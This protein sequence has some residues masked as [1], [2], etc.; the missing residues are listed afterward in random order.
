MGNKIVIVGLLIAL[1][2]ILLPLPVYAQTVVDGDVGHY[3][4]FY[5]AFQRMSFAAND[6]LW[7]FYVDTDTDDLMYRTSDDS[8]A[9]WA[10]EIKIF[11]NAEYGQ[12]VSVEYD[13]TYTYIVASDVTNTYFRRGT[14][15]IDGTFTWSTAWQNTEIGGGSVPD[16]CVDSNG[17]PYVGY[18]WSNYGNVT[19]SSTNDGTWVTDTGN[20]F[21]YQFS[22]TDTSWNVSVVGL[23]NGRVA[24]I[25]SDNNGGENRKIRVSTWTG[26]AWRTERVTVAGTTYHQAVP[27][28]DDLHI[29][30]LNSASDDITYVKYTYNTNSLGAETVLEANGDNYS[31]PVITMTNYNDLYVFWPNGPVA[32]HIYYIKYSNYIGSWGDRVDFVDESIADGIPDSMYYMNCDEE[33]DAATIP[34]YWV[35]DNYSLKVKLVS[36]TASV[37]TLSPSGITAT[38]ATLRGEVTATGTGVITASGFQINTTPSATGSTDVPHSCPCGLGVF[39]EP[40]TG[41]EADE[42]YYYRAYATNVN[43]TVYGSWEIFL[44]DTQGAGAPPDQPDEPDDGMTPPIPTTGPVGWVTDPTTRD[45]DGWFLSDLLNPF[46]DLISRSFVWFCVMVF[47]I[48]AIGIALCRFTRHLGITFLALG[49]VLGLYIGGG[50]LDWWILFPYLIVGIALIVK[51]Q[52]YGWG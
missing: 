31:P 34:L 50:Y 26:L 49:M 33:V 24:A 13:G 16:I 45:F 44:T 7:V 25:R 9:T 20:N 14:P 23:T 8:G 12:R 43:G 40:V 28:D 17:Y 39:N 15:N 5:L 6:L 38:G 22:G 42:L 4:A 37:N 35:A 47:V 52:Q 30:F 21:P 46:F 36:E 48:A 18:Q 3:Q 11:D 2:T 32:D 10:G 27:Q 19:K 51:E 1:V 29:T 41:L